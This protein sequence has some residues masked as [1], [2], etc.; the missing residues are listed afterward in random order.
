MKG[1]RPSFRTRS[2]QAQC[3]VLVEAKPKPWFRAGEERAKQWASMRLGRR[4]GGRVRPCCP[5]EP[6][7]K[8]HYCRL[9]GSVTPCKCR[10]SLKPKKKVNITM[11]ALVDTEAKGQCL[12]SARQCDTTQTLVEP[13]A[14][15]Q[16]LQTVTLP[17]SGGNHGQRSMLAGRSAT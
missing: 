13:V 12:Q 17:S 8:V 4:L 5:V 9:L 3:K 11:Q 6:A 2:E 10:L 15:G 1:T 14:K 7:A 16:C